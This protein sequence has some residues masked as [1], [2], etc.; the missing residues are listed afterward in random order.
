MELVLPPVL[1]LLMVIKI[2]SLARNVISLALNVLV[3]K[4]QLVLLV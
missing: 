2:V 4:Y 1:I 3:E